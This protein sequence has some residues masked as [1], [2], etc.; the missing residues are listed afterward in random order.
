MEIHLIFYSFHAKFFFNVYKRYRK[1]TKQATSACERWER[2][3]KA[4]KQ[5]KS[6]VDKIQTKPQTNLE[7]SYRLG[8]IETLNQKQTNQI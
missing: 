1:S 8:T 4:S 6:H 2:M 5:T 7:W 3:R